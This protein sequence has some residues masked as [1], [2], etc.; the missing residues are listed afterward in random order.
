[1][2]STD[3]TVDRRDILF[4]QQELLQVQ[5]LT[6]L[7]RFRGFGVEDFEMVVQE[8]A[9]FVEEVYAPLNKPGDETGSRLVDGKVV[10][11]PGFKE[12]WRKAAEAGWIGM[13]S[14]PEHGGQGLPLSVAVGVLEAMYGSNPALYTTAMLTAGAAGL[15]SHFGS[16]Q[17]KAT[18]C[19]KMLSGQWGGTMCLSEANAG[20]AVGDIATRAVK[21]PGAEHYLIKGNK[22]W[23]SGGDHDFTENNIHLVLA[24]AAGSPPGPKGISLFIVPKLR[25]D[26]EGRPTVPNDVTT[27]RLEHKLG[28]KASPTCV[29]EFGARDDCHG[30]LLEGENL[31]MMQMFR[32]MNEARL[33]VAYQGL[34]AASGAFRNALAYARERTQGVPI[35]KGKDP[36]QPR[37]AI[38]HHPDVRNALMT[39]KA[40]TEGMRGL[41]YAVAFYSDLAHHG[42]AETRGHYQDLVDILTPVAKNAGADQGFEVVRLGIQVLGGVGFTEEFPLAQHLRDTKIAS[43]YEGT[44][45]IQALDLVTRKLTVRGGELFRSLQQEIGGLTSDQGAGD[46]VRQAIAA[47]GEAVERLKLTVA[48]VRNLAEEL[49]PREGVFHATDLTVFFGDVMSAYYLLRMA[50]IAEEKLRALSGGDRLDAAAVRALAEDN[51]EAAFYFNKI[52]TA[53]H[54]V[55]QILPR[56]RA[57]A[58]KVQSRNFAALEAVL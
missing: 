40:L 46:S 36:T 29:L 30:T 9:T 16:E 22:T 8:G 26:G 41:I 56:G 13:I 43:I 57:V 28:I 42:P 23:I 18:F 33:Q 47:W 48:S 55:F 5:R 51:E 27:L 53:E 32:L 49:G 4:V 39:M 19:E 17:Q 20:S 38:V 44:T 50:L 34:G 45:G 10:T 6:E 14:E 25:L 52:K 54:Y 12:A 24:R 15:I 37:A 58:A 2:N 31:G 3:Y 11:P 7:E 35:E 1:M 21:A